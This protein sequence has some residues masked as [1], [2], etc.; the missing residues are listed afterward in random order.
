MYPFV[1]VYT[2][3]A[4]GRKLRYHL[5]SAC[6]LHCLFFGISL[7]LIGFEPMYYNMLLALLAYSCYLTLNNC[8]ICAYMTLLVFA[9]A[10]GL[11][12][13]IAYS[14]ESSRYD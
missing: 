4:W 7:A 14:D 13:G 12:W 6:I 9:I 3:T 1:P 11:T 2:S 10:G 8:T 5:L